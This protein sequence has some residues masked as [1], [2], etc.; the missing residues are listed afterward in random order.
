[1]NNQ[2]TEH[3]NHIY[4]TKKLEEVSWYQPIPQTSL[5]LILGSDL[6]KDEPVID[7]GGGDSFLVD[8][9]LENDF[10]D[11]TVL[12]ISS[13]A[14]ERAKQRLGKRAQEVH[15]IISNI[16]DF[17][18]SREYT[19]WHDRAVFHFIREKKNI[20]Q[21]YKN[22]VK[23][24]NK[25]GRLILATFSENGPERCCALDVKRY[26]ISQ[27][28]DLFSDRFTPQNTLNTN[29]KTPSGK[30]QKFSFVELIKNK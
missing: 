1:M 5:N 20:Q 17:V 11:I 3:W 27:L 2:I 7:V 9:L 6:S 8:C 19:I 29:H 23:G 18:P 14:I 26:S 12:D 22:V 15:W 4:D 10:S 13:V 24:V 28:C 25:N 16:I 21:Y 30:E